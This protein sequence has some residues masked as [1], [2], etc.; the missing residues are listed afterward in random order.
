MALQLDARGLGPSGTYY[1]HKPRQDPR[2]FKIL[3]GCPALMRRLKA[4][5]EDVFLARDVR[6]RVSSLRHGLAGPIKRGW[7]ALVF[8][9][10]HPNTARGREKAAKKAAAYAEDYGVQAVAPLRA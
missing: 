9:P 4:T 7:I 3:P 10:G 6:A 5:P 1:D 8:D 2:T